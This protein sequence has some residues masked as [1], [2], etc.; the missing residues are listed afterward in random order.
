[1]KKIYILVTMVVLGIAACQQPPKVVTIDIK[2]EKNVIDTMFKRFT[3]SFNEA[4]VPVMASYLSEDA[5]CMGT[6]PSE[7]WNKQQVVEMWTQMLS[8]MTPELNYIGERKILVA[9]DGNSATVVDQYM[10]PAICNIPWRNVYQ[11]VKTDG[12]WKIFVFN[13][14]FVPKNEDIQKL[15]EAIK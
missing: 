4:G 1:M 15:S 6:D 8:G 9:P 12:K 7:M 11:L 5:L 14:A 10:M 13:V 3:S 2:A